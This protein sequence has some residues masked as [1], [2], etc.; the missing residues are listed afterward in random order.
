MSARAVGLVLPIVKRYY[1]AGLLV[2][3]DKGYCTR[4]RRLALKI[5]IKR[6]SFWIHYKYTDPS[7]RI[8]ELPSRHQV[9]LAFLQEDEEK[10]ASRQLDEDEQAVTVASAPP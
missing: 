2:L 7:Q 5:H 6:A 3:G 4:F 8:N 10:K 9:V 1:S